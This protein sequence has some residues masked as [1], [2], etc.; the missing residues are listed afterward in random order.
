MGV[1]RL[2]KKED[3]SNEIP[4]RN[5]EEDKDSDADLSEDSEPESPPPSSTHVER[6]RALNEERVRLEQ[7]AQ[8]CNV[9][10]QKLNEIAENMKHHVE[11]IERELKRIKSIRLTRFIRGPIN[12]QPPTL[13][14]YLATVT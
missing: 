2:P 10:S 4:E 3:N 14:P 13:M 7:E 9:S 5:D 12:E 1:E 6:M 8:E 11:V